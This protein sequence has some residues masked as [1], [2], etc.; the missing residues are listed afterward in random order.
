MT[1]VKNLEKDIEVVESGYEFL[2]AYAAQGRPPHDEASYP[3]PHARPTLED[4]LASMQNVLAALGETQHEY[5]LVI[6]EDLRKA[7]ATL[8]FVL[9]QPLMSSELVDNLNASI[10]LRAVLTDFFLYS[11]IFKPAAA[12]AKPAAESEPLFR[13]A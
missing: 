10:H 2:L 6:A 9:A 12:E 4:M 8:R 7:S 3:T 11:E 1:D 13:K 5:E